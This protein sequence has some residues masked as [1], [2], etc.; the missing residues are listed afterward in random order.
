MGTARAETLRQ[1][2]IESGLLGTW[3]L[4]CSRK[5]DHDKGALFSYELKPDG[6]VIY[7][8]NF[9]DRKDENEVVAAAVNEDGV[10][11]LVVFFPGLHQARE[12]G[13]VVQ[14]DGSLRAHYNRDQ[15]GHYTIRDGKFVR[16]GA[17]TPD[18]QKCSDTPHS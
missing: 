3:S 13:V 16:T 1:V 12:F 8:R 14:D 17:E 7:S 9:G 10:I 11:E 18:Q 2:I 5:P 15:K 6:R 4:D